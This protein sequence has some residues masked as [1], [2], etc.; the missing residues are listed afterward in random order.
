LL[1]TPAETLIL[2]SFCSSSLVEQLWVDRG[3]TT[4]TRYPEREHQSLVSIAKRPDSMLS[5]AYTPAGKIVGEVTLAPADEWWGNNRYI[6]EIAIQVSSH[7][8][9]FGIA[10]HL[11]TFALEWE[12]VEKAILLAMGLSWHWDTRGLGF[13]PYRYR[14]LIASLFEAHG[15]DEYPTSEPN[16][17]MDPV[18]ILLVRIGHLVDQETLDQFFQHL[19]NM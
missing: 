18:N 3:L 2:Q 5:L 4:F 6:Y 12:A 10:H 7:W 13:T 11:L 15:F 9:R 8:R 17:C 16:I 1:K 14:Q 19:L